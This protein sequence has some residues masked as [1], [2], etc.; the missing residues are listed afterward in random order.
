MLHN[1]I[2]KIV[3]CYP[4]YLY[5]NCIIVAVSVF[6]VCFTLDDK[7]EEALPKEETNKSDL[8]SKELQKQIEMEIEA[9]CFPCD[10]HFTCTITLVTPGE[11]DGR[12]G[13]SKRRK[14]G[15]RASEE[16]GEGREMVCLELQWLEGNMD[17]DQL[18]QIMQYLSNKM[19]QTKWT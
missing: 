17:K 12:G 7:Q 16:G 4:R 1:I 18:H 5:A 13:C 2:L 3:E 6:L 8:F 14:K 19:D 9:L 10:L 15:K 11:T